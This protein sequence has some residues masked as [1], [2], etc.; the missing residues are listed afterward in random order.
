M[1]HFVCL[2]SCVFAQ[3]DVTRRR[4]P[5]RRMATMIPM[6]TTMM[7][8]TSVSSSS[9][10]SIS[11]ATTGSRAPL[12]RRFKW[13]VEAACGGGGA[14]ARATVTV[15]SDRGRDPDEQR[16]IDENKRWRRDQP[17]EEVWDIDKERDA[18]MYKRESLERLLRLTPAKTNDDQGKDEAKKDDAGD[19]SSSS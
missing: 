5:V 2:C 9:H 3:Q 8:M 6:T 12:P 11:R 14:R 1:R 18:L 19:A 10:A 17:P 13:R 4:F 16:R 7:K 15:A